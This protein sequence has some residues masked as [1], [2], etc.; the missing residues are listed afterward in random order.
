MVLAEIKVIRLHAGLISILELLFLLINLSQFTG[1][2]V[3]NKE[4]GRD[5]V[6]SECLW[7]N[8]KII[9]LG[10]QRILPAS[11]LSII[12]FKEEPGAHLQNYKLL[13][14]LKQL[15]DLLHGKLL[16]TKSH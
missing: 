1:G 11:V 2:N 9:V 4:N 3:A 10:I 7:N 5:H 8:F 14:K 16:R 15:T 12:F 13:G 6:P